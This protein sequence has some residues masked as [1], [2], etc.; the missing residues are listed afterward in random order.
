MAAQRAQAVAD[1]ARESLDSGG[2]ELV[3]RPLSH[4][5]HAAESDKRLPPRFGRS[6]PGATVL[7]GLLLD[8][9][10]DLVREPVFELLP[11]AKKTKPPPHVSKSTHRAPQLAIVTS[12]T[13]LIAR[14]MRRHCTSD[15]FRWR[16]PLAVSE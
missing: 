10:P 13:R 4:V 7:L 3:P 6:H 5:F 12:R 1:V 9:E 14:D 15:S 2:S 8:M 16:R 11:A